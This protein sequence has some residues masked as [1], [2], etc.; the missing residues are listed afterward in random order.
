MPNTR[1]KVRF[2]QYFYD[3]DK[4]M[5]TYK[6]IEN[7]E[8]DNNKK[9]IIESIRKEE[10]KHRE[11]WKKMAEKNGEN[12]KEKRYPLIVK[13]YAILYSL[14]GIDFIFSLSEA[15]ERKAIEKYYYVYE[16]YPLSN[17]EKKELKSIILDELSHENKL[18]HLHK[19]RGL[20]EHIRD[21]FLGMNDGLVEIL[22]TLAGLVSLNPFKNTLLIGITGI[23]VG[24]S[25]TLSMALGNYISVKNQ[26][27]VK[28][29][30]SMAARII[31]LLGGKGNKKVEEITE[32]PVKSAYITGLFYIVGTVLVVYPFFLFSS[33]YLALIISVLSA[34]LAWFI[35]GWVVA[36]SSGLSPTKKSLEMIL[37][38][39]S[40]ATISYLFGY[41]IHILLWTNI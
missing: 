12:V 23:I 41:L 10:E 11:F 30:R 7:L 20:I 33:S 28:E 9:K 14:L 25:G 22:S 19:D 38:G 4:D 1:N 36:L 17:K 32:D 13:I 39:L 21:I 5:K 27:E 3:E 18:I 34:T 2:S 6:T 35:S 26:K 16:H 15:G 40:A 31:K 8:K 24:V 37:I 29:S